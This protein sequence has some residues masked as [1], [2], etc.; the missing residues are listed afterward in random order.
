MAGFRAVD[1]AAGLYATGKTEILRPAHVD[2]YQVIVM[3]FCAEDR[4]RY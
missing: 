4:R 1:T 2:V 3:S